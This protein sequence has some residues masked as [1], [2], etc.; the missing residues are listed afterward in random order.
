MAELAVALLAL[1]AH[2]ERVFTRECAAHA[3]EVA[4]AKGNCQD[5]PQARR[6][7]AR[8]RPSATVTIAR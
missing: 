6:Q 3:R 5:G 2:M 1:F 8:A 7:P 4:Q